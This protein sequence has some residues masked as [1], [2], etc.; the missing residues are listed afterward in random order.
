MEGG[1]FIHYPWPHVP[2]PRIGAGGLPRLNYHVFGGDC[3]VRCGGWVR[4]AYEM[5]ISLVVHLLELSYIQRGNPSWRYT[6]FGRMFLHLFVCLPFGEE[7]VGLMEV[8]LGI[9]HRAN[10]SNAIGPIE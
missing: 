1:Y 3:G 7:R 9:R 6:V 8:E 5:C 2:L 10:S 4:N